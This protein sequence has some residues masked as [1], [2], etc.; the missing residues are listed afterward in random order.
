[1]PNLLF[2]HTEGLAREILPVDF[3]GVENISQFIA[4]ETVETGVVSVQLGAFF[5]D[6]GWLGW[7][8]E[9]G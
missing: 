1:M 7:L 6:E 5:A 9:H 4:S 2:Q 8:A 3:F